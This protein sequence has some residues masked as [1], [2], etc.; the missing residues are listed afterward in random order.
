MKRYNTL[1]RSVR[2]MR[3]FLVVLSIVG[4]ICLIGGVVADDLSHST[5][6]TSKTWVIANGKDSSTIMIMLKEPNGTALSSGVPV[7]FSLGNSTMGSI[8]L[9]NTMTDSTGSASTI[10]TTNKISG[11]ATIGITVIY[12]GTTSYFNYTQQI[13]H[14][15][16]YYWTVTSPY[17]GT[18]GTE[19]YFNVSYTDQWHNVIDHRNP[20]DPY[21]IS[22]N[23]GSVAGNAAFDVNGA[24]VTSTTQNLDNY[25]NLSVKVLLDTVVGQN[26]IHIYPFYPNS[27]GAIPDV[28]PAIIGISNGVPVAITATTN[29]TPPQEPADQASTISIEY[30]LYDKYGNPT[31]GQNITIT[32]SLGESFSGLT[33]N[34]F[35]EIGFTYGPKAAAGTITLTATAVA[36]SSVTCSE[37]VTFYNTAPVNWVLSADPQIMPSLDVNSNTVSKITGQVMDNMGN[38]VPN[39]TVTFNLGTPSYDLATDNITSQPQLSSLSGLTGSNISVQSDSNGNAIINF[40]PGSFSTASTTSYYNPQATGTCSV[41]GTWNGASQNVLLTWKNYPYLSA[42]TS[43]VPANVTLNGTVNVTIKLT[44]DGWALTPNPIDAVVLMDRS[45][46]MGNSM[47]DGNTEMKDAQAG[48]V[49][50]ANQMNSSSDR[51]AVVSFSGLSPNID[52]KVNQA[53]TTNITLVT[54][55]INSLSPTSATGTRDGLYQAITL[56]KNNPNANPKA[57][58]AIILL[59]D[60]DYNW[61]GDPVGRGTGYYPGPNAGGYT[62]YSQS[63]LEPSKYMIY[64]GLGC[65]YTPVPVSSHPHT[66]SLTHRI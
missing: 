7:T 5:I 13:D 49:L 46:S 61:L 3:G 10:F 30:T 55:A 52:T 45:G 9:T 63:A 58:R 62:G 4:L 6:T 19:T 38:P 50:F 8:S 48:A 43:V 35:G 57:T 25:G 53:L 18:A 31:V 64:S 39:Q 37:N 12:N 17:E 51:L 15:V 41:T 24:H 22:L 29:P 59:T 16:P 42:Y 20:A 60:G 27:Q 26:N 32:S 2:N 23:I 28:Y 66:N 40:I 65:S 21:A 47:S 36:N 11:S 56:L 1:F 54:N 34:D 44:G 14:D 33:S